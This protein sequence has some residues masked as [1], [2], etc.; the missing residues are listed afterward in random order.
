MKKIILLAS[1][2]LSSCSSEFDSEINEFNLICNAFISLADNKEL[3]KLSAEDRDNFIMHE[4]RALN[5]ES[6]AKAGWNAVKNAVAEERYSLY[7][8]VVD[9]IEGGDWSCAAMEE[10]AS[11][12]EIDY[13]E[14]ELQR[15]KPPEP[16]TLENAD[17]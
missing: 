11:S 16:T 10:L 14:E 15:E 3:S 4:I 2:V 12:I 5:P 1:I 8:N 17:F 7:K 6:N 9:S 13:T